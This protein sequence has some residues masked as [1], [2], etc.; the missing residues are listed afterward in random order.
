MSS[1]NPSYKHPLDP[2]T[3]DEIQVVIATVR[4][5]HPNALFNIVSLHEPRKATL[6]K[7]L[8]QRSPETNPPR[9]ADV[10]IILP[11]GKVADIIVDVQTETIVE[12]SFVTGMQPIV[13]KKPR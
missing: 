2:L 12:C 6:S 10:C 5:I 7:W 8:V 1:T 11:G 4:V 13:S 3:S 9:L